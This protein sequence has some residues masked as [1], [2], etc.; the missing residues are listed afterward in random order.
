[1]H[2]LLHCI[3]CTYQLKIYN[4]TCIHT[5]FNGYLKYFKILLAFH[6]SAQSTKCY[7]EWL[8]LQLRNAPYH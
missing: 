1:M 8:S 5:G 2:E 3:S 6:T 4:D 7:L